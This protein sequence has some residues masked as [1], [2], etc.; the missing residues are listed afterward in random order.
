[1]TR[2]LVLGGTGL[3]GKPVS[4][5]LVRDG[6]AVRVLSR[7]PEEAR[8]TLGGAVEVVGGDVADKDSL[9]RA[10]DGCQA[11]HISIGGKVDQLSA[12]NVAALAVDS[13]LGRI[14]YVSG[15]TVSEQN[16]WFPMTEQ[17]LNAEAAISACGVPY[18]VFCP[19]W[20]MEQLPRFARGGSPS[21]I[22]KQPAPVHWFAAEDLGRSRS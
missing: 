12:E 16:R 7:H 8:A 10:L 21:M 5:A 6:F 19:T 9:A 3:L 22:G 4:R 1:M 20:P 14:G 15:S 18:T 11:T 2:I 17:K 13:G